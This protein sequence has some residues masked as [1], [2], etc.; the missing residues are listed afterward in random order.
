MPEN[1][2]REVAVDHC[3]PVAEMPDLLARLVGEAA[4][5]TSDI[6]ME[7]NKLTE[8]EIKIAR[9]D[10]A[11]EAG[12]MEMGELSPYTCPD[13]HGV[14]SKFREGKRSRFR[15]HTGHAFS[16]DS[17]LATVTESVEEG[18]WSAIRGIEE[19]VMLLNHLGNH[20]VDLDQPDLAAVYFKKA[21]EAEQ[22]AQSVREAVMNHEQL[23]TDQ[24]NRQS[25]NGQGTGK[26]E[27]SSAANEG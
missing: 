27:E 11:F 6:I 22:R 9:E 3:L 23:S 14:L 19:S 26:N 2:L 13:C 5:E 10:S 21:L 4:G 16:A 8:I 1:A 18:L 20:Y 24:L 7:E 12:I 17:L 15:C 25:G